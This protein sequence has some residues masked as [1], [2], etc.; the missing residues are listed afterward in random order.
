MC[1]KDACD[2]VL[3]ATWEVER[4]LWKEARGWSKEKRKTYSK[5]APDNFKGLHLTKLCTCGYI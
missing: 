5:R 3:E 2:A 1:R 4:L